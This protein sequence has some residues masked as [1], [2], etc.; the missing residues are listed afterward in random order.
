MAVRLRVP[1]LLAE[2]QM[3]AY[4]LSK[5]SEGRISLSTAYRLA[6]GE[7]GEISATAIDSLC[8]VFGVEPGALF[9]RVADPPKRRKSA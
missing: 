6:S 8:D 4:G 9:V 3:T 7:F 1:E 2:R 5:A